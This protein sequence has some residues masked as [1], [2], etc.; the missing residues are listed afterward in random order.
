MQFMKFVKKRI[1]VITITI[2]DKTKSF[3]MKAKILVWQNLPGRY[4]CQPRRF[5]NQYLM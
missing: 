1:S 2:L 3:Y 5:C 4:C